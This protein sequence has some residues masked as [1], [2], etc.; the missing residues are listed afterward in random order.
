MTSIGG[1]I[2]LSLQYINRRLILLL[3]LLILLLFKLL[4]LSKS[5]KMPFIIAIIFFF[6][7]TNSLKLID[8]NILVL[9]R[10][11]VHII[12]I[13]HLTLKSS[14]SEPSIIPLFQILLLMMTIQ[15]TRLR[16]HK[17][18]SLILLLLLLLLIL[19]LLLLRDILLRTRQLI[20]QLKQIIKLIY[21][22]ITITI[23]LL[24]LQYTASTR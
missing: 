11:A 5:V 23:T 14:W 13:F 3:L 19:L 24:F 21:I 10:I 9:K 4:L 18:L 22:I 17:F 2:A 16:V 15:P 12:I 20:F 6:L 1:Q 7:R 8:I